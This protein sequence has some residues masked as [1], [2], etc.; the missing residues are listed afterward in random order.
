MDG[1]VYPA[2]FGRRGISA[3]L[4]GAADRELVSGIIFD[5]LVKG[6]FTDSAREEYVRVIERLAGRGCVGV[7]GNPAPDHARGVAATRVRRC[8]NA[9]NAATS[10]LF[11]QCQG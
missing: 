10:A 9:R 2:A 3:E 11:V 5:E 4:P 8:R 1:P 7:Q 6:V